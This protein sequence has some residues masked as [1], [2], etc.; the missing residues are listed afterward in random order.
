LNYII[1]DLEAACWL[2]RPP[3]GHNEIIE[4]GAIKVNRY[5]EVEEVFS[6]F[7][8]PVINPILSDFC[9]KLTSITQEDINRAK[10]FS[11]VGKE[12]QDWINIYEDEFVLCSWG[13]YDI[14]LLKLDCRLHKLDLD[15]LEFNVNLKDSYKRIK[16]EHH[17]TGLKSTLKK[18]GIEFTGMHHRAIS[19][20][21]NLAKL[22][23]KY[24][25]D[26]GI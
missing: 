24:L 10:D 6:K 15:W 20:A 14:E 9:T 25:E 17:R 16:G 8:K 1:Y 2:G 13:K 22:F 3:K 26:W 11:I 21:E 19:D 4:I 12:F 18:E 23:I 7:V 5:G